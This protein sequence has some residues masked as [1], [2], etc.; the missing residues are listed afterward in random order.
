MTFLKPLLFPLL[1]LV[2]TSSQAG[3]VLPQVPSYRVDSS[4]VDA[5]DLL[6]ARRRLERYLQASEKFIDCLDTMEKTAQGTGRESD[7]RRRKRISDY[8]KV[9]A[10]TAKAVTAY[11][12]QV[13]QFKATE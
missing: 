8:N 2:A 1:L 5:E 6:Y 3:C 4:A 13:A 10:D 9:M 11:N 7:S 12:A